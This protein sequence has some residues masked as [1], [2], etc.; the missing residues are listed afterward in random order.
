[1]AD[2]AAV[3]PGGKAMSLVAVIA[4]SVRAGFV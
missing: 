1:M 2:G 4:V 3:N